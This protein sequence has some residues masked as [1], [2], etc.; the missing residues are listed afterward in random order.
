MP[1]CSTVLDRDPAFGRRFKDLRGGTGPRYASD[2]TDPEWALIAED[3]APA[4]G[5]ETFGVE[6]MFARFGKCRR[7]N[8]EASAPTEFAWL[9][10]ADLRLLTRRLARS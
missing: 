9:L 6:R 5:T 4:A 3:A 1:T 8:F 7:R 10:V 2:L